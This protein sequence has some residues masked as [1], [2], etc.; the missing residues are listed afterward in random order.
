VWS[1]TLGP[2]FALYSVCL[3]V[4]RTIRIRQITLSQR[5]KA[6]QMQQ[7]QQQ[8]GRYPLQQQHLQHQQNV[9]V[10]H[11]LQQQQK[12]QYLQQ[13]LRKK[14]QQRL[15][16]YSPLEQQQQQQ[17]DQLTSEPTP[18]TI[19]AQ[20]QHTRTQEH[21]QQRLHQHHLLPVAPVEHKAAGV[22]NNM[23]VPPFFRTSKDSAAKVS[24]DGVVHTEEKGG[25]DRLSRP[26]RRSRKSLGTKLTD[27]AP[28]LPCKVLM[29]FQC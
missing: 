23:P 27:Q 25:L 26:P 17:H 24:A 2:H 13:R 3:G 9:A 4:D 21:Q 14:Q 19:L 6:L 29:S 28:D 18:L 5:R 10:Q 20:K 16:Q 1:C 11:Q 7:Q 22:Q 12:Q 8:Q 15:R